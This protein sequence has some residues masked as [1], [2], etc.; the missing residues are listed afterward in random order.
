[1]APFPWA[2][3]PAGILALFQRWCHLPGP[4]PKRIHGR[5]SGFAS[6]A[7]SP[8]VAP[9]RLYLGQCTIPWLPPLLPCMECGCA[10]VRFRLFARG[11]FRGATVVATASSPLPVR[12][13]YA[14]KHYRRPCDFRPDAFAVMPAGQRSGRLRKQS[15][16]LSGLP[17]PP[18]TPPVSP[19]P[20]CA[21]FKSWSKNC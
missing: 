11:T 9:P 6:P 20:R 17:A 5:W 2:W 19:R 14:A 16:F 7:S 8:G 12:F 3:F 10:P 13:F 18:S 15:G 21:R 1:M 4:A